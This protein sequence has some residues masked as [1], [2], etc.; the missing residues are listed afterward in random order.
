MKPEIDSNK[1]VVFTGAGISAESGLQTFRDSNGLWNDFRVED[2]ATPEAWAS[3]PELV[4][5]FYNDRRKQAFDAAPNAAHD[6]VTRLEEKYEVIVITQNVDD[7]HERSGSTNVIHVHGQLKYARSSNNDSLLYLYDE[8]KP[9]QVGDVCD[10]G[11]QL[12]PHIVWFGENIQNYELARKHLV[13]AGRVLVVGTSLSV[14]PAA[15]ILKKAR[16]NAEKIII[17]RQIDKKPSGY[18]LL[19]G[20]AT[21]LVPSVIGDWLNGKKVI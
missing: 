21:T 4:L 19:R 16:F 11:S 6:A 17:T 8:G 13:T 15:G 14:Y 5:Q 1:I 10:E 2:V 20:S 9:I 12:R 18:K 3:N 7:L